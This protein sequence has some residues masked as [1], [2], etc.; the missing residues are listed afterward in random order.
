MGLRNHQESAL[1]L[2]TLVT[3]LDTDM[4]LGA[5]LLT[6]LFLAIYPFLIL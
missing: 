4:L 6:L 3:G 2:L 1:P 5:E